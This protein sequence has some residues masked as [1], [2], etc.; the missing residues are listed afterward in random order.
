MKI[1]QTAIGI[2]IALV[3]AFVFLGAHTYY[4]TNPNEALWQYYGIEKCTIQYSFGD[5][6]EANKLKVKGARVRTFSEIGDRYGHD[7]RDVYYEGNI[8]KDAD[9][10]SFAKI[11]GEYYKDKNAVYWQGG[12]VDGAN[13]ESFT[14]FP[15]QTLFARDSLNEY[16]KGKSI[17]VSVF[18]LDSF[19]ISPIHKDQ[20]Q[21][22]SQKTI[23]WDT[24]K[25]KE[26]TLLIAI[27]AG[28]D[29]IE[30]ITGNPITNEG[31]YVWN[32]STT[33][34]ITAGDLVDMAF[35]AQVDNEK[36]HKYLFREQFLF[37]NNPES[38]VDVRVNLSEHTTVSP[39]SVVYITWAGS[40][41]VQC[42]G[43]NN[44]PIEAIGHAFIRFT[45][46]KENT[47]NNK[48]S[49]SIRC[50]SKNGEV[51]E[52]TAYITVE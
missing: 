9:P 34:S 49:Y 8:I 13:T 1:N 52:D 2:G 14:V 21:P 39:G 6:E 12:V 10:I 29:A 45:T 23:F 16:Y 40:N 7:G 44:S 27:T 18:D 47:K 32:V 30:W 24:G 28:S 11:G 43:P 33:T 4:C 19:L 26:K 37:T 50:T 51:V 17:E 3:I 42:F 48:F 15:K 22:G 25:I 38:I 5:E 31:I 41:I 20:I 36:M 35:Y 46:E